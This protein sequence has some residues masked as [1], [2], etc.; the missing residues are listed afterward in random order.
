MVFRFNVFF[1]SSR[2]ECSIQGLPCGRFQPT[3]SLAGLAPYLFFRLTGMAFRRKFLFSRCTAERNS[4]PPRP[5][6]GASLG[7]SSHQLQ[8]SL[9]GLLAFATFRLHELQG[10]TTSFGDGCL[11]SPPSLRLGS[12]LFQRFTARQSLFWHRP[13]YEFPGVRGRSS[14]LT[15]SEAFAIP[16]EF[17]S[18]WN[19]RHPFAGITLPRRRVSSTT[20]C[21][22]SG[23]LPVYRRPSTGRR[24]FLPSGCHHPSNFDFLILS[25]SGSDSAPRISFRCSASRR[26][27]CLAVG[28]P[29][30]RFSD[31]IWRLA[32]RGQERILALDGFADSHRHLPT[33]LGSSGVPV[34]AGFLS[35]LSPFAICLGLAAFTPGSR[36]FLRCTAGDRHSSEGFDEVR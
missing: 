11:R 21:G 30:S 31:R 3:A 7:W 29:G 5:T 6:L 27:P 33:N 17:H 13:G 23:G 36:S 34:E 10:G 2:R 1:N 32:F 18:R 25:G 24:V 4:Y 15:T 16:F 19:H 35:G 12:R 9:P 8:V 22:R 20:L 28:A 26:S 14:D